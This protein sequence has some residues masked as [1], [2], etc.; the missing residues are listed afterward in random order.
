MK[1]L[2]LLILFFS[3]KASACW[4]LTAEVTLN[5]EKLHIDQKFE[6]GRTYSFPKGIYIVHLR[7]PND[8][9]VSGVSFKVKE[10][11]STQLIEL[12]NEAI[13]L[14]NDKANVTL[15]NIKAHFVTNIE[16]KLTDI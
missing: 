2:S 3:L 5:N 14:K 8:F 4:N 15:N 6:H 16:L 11:K 13:K 10:K 9:Q 1:F 12:A 7:V